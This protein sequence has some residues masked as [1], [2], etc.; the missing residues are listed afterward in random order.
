M[1]YL[2]SLFIVFFINFS[3]AAVITDSSAPNFELT[4]SFGG[5]VSLSSFKGSTVV[6]EWTNH[7]CPYVAKHY[8]SG[9]FNIKRLPFFWAY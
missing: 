6:L 5:D 9:N 1:K 2:L 7:D 4:N 3:S 8:R